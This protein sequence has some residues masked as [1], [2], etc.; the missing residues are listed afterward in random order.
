[1]DGPPGQSIPSV[2]S[3][4][5][6][7]HAPVLAREVVRLAATARRVVDGT[8]GGGGHTALL[9]GTG[10]DVLAIDRD[11]DALTAARGRVATDRVRFLEA[12]FASPAARAA[13]AAFRPDVI[14]L[15]LGVSSHQFDEDAR[16]FSFRRGVPLDMRMTP[17]V[18]PS[19]AE[20]LNRTP[21]RELAAM[22]RTLADEPRARRLAAEVARRRHGAPFAVSDDLVNAIRGAL[23][24][25]AGPP[26]FARIFQALRL[27]V[28]DEPGELARALPAMRDALVPGGALAVI[29]YHSGE[30]RVVKHAFREWARACVCPPAQPTCT[31]RGRSLGTVEPP[32]GIR[33]ADDEIAGNP[34]ARSA[35]LRVFRTSH[36]G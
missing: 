23:G 8:A 29:T 4:P 15:D 25:R 14:L 24:P 31:C 22:F 21:E 13:V 1:M 3:M 19:A 32:R 12:S 30:D 5:S 16:G 11:P 34:R 17:G 27:V 10:A 26:D 20:V 9:A 28:N 2:P 7:F 36:A 18:G 6:A 35:R 33:P